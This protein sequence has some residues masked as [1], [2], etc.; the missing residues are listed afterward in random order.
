MICC[1]VSVDATLLVRGEYSAAERMEDDVEACDG[2]SEWVAGKGE[3]V[4]RGA[5]SMARSSQRV[6]KRTMTSRGRVNRSNWQGW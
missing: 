6:L 1:G 5:S 4:E 2:S 3:T